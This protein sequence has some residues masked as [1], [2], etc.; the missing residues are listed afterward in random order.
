MA[1]RNYNNE[2]KARRLH[3]YA[4]GL[5]DG[6]IHAEQQQQ[7]GLRG[8]KR[9]RAGGI[10]HDD[11]ITSPFL[12]SLDR[13][14]KLSGDKADRIQTVDSLPKP[15]F[16]HIPVDDV[17]VFE[18][19]R[20][21]NDIRG[22]SPE[23]LTEENLAN[24]GLRNVNP[25]ASDGP[26]QLSV[27]MLLGI[28]G[29]LIALFIHFSTDASSNEQQYSY[30]RSRMKKKV[31]YK[32]PNYR[33]KTDEWSDDADINDD[34]DYRGDTEE[35]GTTAGSRS[36]LSGGIAKKRMNIP[37]SPIP[38]MPH[39]PTAR[40]YYNAGDNF[41]QQE[42]RLRKSTT[43]QQTSTNAEAGTPS[44]H[45]RAGIAVPTFQTPSRMSRPSPSISS[46]NMSNRTSFKSAITSYERSPG[47]GTRGSPRGTPMA[48]RIPE[49]SPRVDNNV[50]ARILPTPP[51][52]DHTS[53]IGSGLE[54]FEHS[55]TQEV[56][57]GDDVSEEDSM[58]NA[59]WPGSFDTGGVADEP[60]VMRHN[61]IVKP[62]GTFTPTDSFVAMPSTGDSDGDRHDSF[63]TVVFGTPPLA[64]GEVARP[65]KTTNV[66]LPPSSIGDSPMLTTPEEE[67]L[68]PQRR[69]CSISS[70]I[71]FPTPRV[72]NSTTKRGL[73]RKMMGRNNGMEG[74]ALPFSDTYESHSK[75][76]KVNT[77]DSSNFVGDLRDMPLV[78]N[79]NTSPQGLDGG[80][81][82]RSSDAPRSVLLEEL[83][84]IRME[85]GV[86]GPRWV[87]E[88]EPAPDEPNNDE[89]D[90][91][92]PIKLSE[93]Y[94]SKTGGQNYLHPMFGGDDSSW[95]EPG[96]TDSLEK[97]RQA[98]EN[99]AKLRE[100]SS[101][102]DPADDPRNSIQ[103][104]RKDLT[105]SSDTSSSL[106]SK[107]SFSELKLVE[108]IGGGGFG[109]VWRAKW[110]GTPVAVKVLTGSAQAE[111][112]PKAVIEEFIAEI[113]MVSGMRHPN[114]CLF[115]GACLDPPNRAIVTE[116]CENGSLWDALRSPLSSPYQPADGVTRSSWPLILYDSLTPPPTP[117]VSSPPIAPAGAWPWILVKR[118]ASG[119][120]RGM[121]YLHSGNPPVLH[122]D[123]K[124][125]NILLDESYTA[126]LADFGLSR[127]KAVRSSGMTGNCGT[128]Q[129]M[130][131]EVLCN[132][133]Y[134]E[135][136]DVFSFG[137]IL[138]EMLTKECPYE[139]MT[140]IQC[141]L[142]V[143]NENNRPKIPDWCPQSFRALIKNCVERNPKDRPTF[144]QILAALD[145]LP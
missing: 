93:D 25:M 2:N 100:A 101:V 88:V 32:S 36:L 117:N 57:D 120:A 104:I 20:G 45:S 19:F 59:T 90:G 6:N 16:D 142:S 78:P 1:R 52:L 47:I 64:T 124:S 123:L 29:V 58:N 18:Y 68:S 11:K 118:V 85:S 140:P 51:F 82:P 114:I 103:H 66:T 121:C 136:A 129:W 111:T 87:S 54:S 91:I 127:L 17:E 132:E 61:M 26:W 10:I 38:K 116:L 75:D 42:S 9:N 56:Q 99:E 135:P 72:E 55:I 63:N 34:D 106:S 65:S 79:L 67:L 73:E 98:C 80:Y 134:A 83:H 53:D 130:A 60:M 125:A 13:A 84:L 96:D 71:D 43:T 108:V 97:K 105:E 92:V 39:D 137:I 122:R 40:L 28:I 145:S 23:Y 27:A 110:K 81:I 30:F 14:N 8:R 94:P 62:M 35:A 48:N 49:Y 107:I 109:Q 86:Q 41:R 128:V 143:L 113:N 7:Q 5:G 15:K 112:V 69:Y 44:G 77:D 115:M 12:Q 102:I 89:V 133:A 126:K 119:T 4:P 144:T 24:H 3:Y 138:W 46:S 50:T 31:P 76:V 70:D 37:P 95:Y 22:P 139:G 21:G 131:P 74:F 33:K 141:A